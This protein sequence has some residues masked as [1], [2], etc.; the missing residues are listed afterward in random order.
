MSSFGSSKVCEKLGLAEIVDEKKPEIEM[1]DEEIQNRFIAT[2]KRDLVIHSSGILISQPFHV[3][4]VR[5]MAEFVGGEGR[6]TSMFGSIAEIFREQGIVGFFSGFFPRLMYDLSCLV[7]TSTT[8]Y[9][10]NKHYIKD[11]ETRGYVQQFIQIIGTSIFYP[12]QVVSTCM[13]VSGSGLVIARPPN[14]PSYSNWYDC[15]RHLR[16]TNQLKRGSSLFWR[17]HIPS[18]NRSRQVASVVPMPEP[19]FNLKF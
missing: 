14:M 18:G 1:S 15:W 11:K 5:M 19:Q 6:Y 10:I 8:V 4:S 9:L 12:L 3:I 7:L 13:V 16:S 17:Y 2:L